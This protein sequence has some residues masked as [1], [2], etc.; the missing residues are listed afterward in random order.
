M[1]IYNVKKSFGRFTLDV[2]KMDIS[3]AKVYGIIGANGSGKSTL[4]QLF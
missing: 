4:L 1:R 2:E 3:K